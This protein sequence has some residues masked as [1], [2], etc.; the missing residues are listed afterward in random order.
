MIFEHKAPV[1][2]L[3]FLPL[4]VVHDPN[5]IELMSFAYISSKYGHAMQVR[6]DGSRYF[7]HPK[8]AAWIYI[9][10][11]GGRDPRVICD[12]L[13][14]DLREDSRLLSTYRVNLN[15]GTDIA[16]DLCSLTK[17][18][19][20]KETQEEYL[21]R[22]IARGPWTILSK[23]CDR[24][25]NIRSLGGCAPE[26]QK[27]QVIETR[28]VLM[29]LLLNALQLCGGDWAMYAFNLEFKLKEALLSL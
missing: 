28:D 8:S 6:D 29:P 21:Q 22:I 19:K 3:F 17:L 25:H 10:E 2:D 14:H 23:L 4:V 9:N 15:F 13:L 12:I 26:K 1:Y 24:L 18:Q 20:G 16:L 7:D 27:R 5:T 11:L